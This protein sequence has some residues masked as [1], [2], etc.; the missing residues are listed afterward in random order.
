MSTHH[1]LPEQEA[2]GCAGPNLKFDGL[3]YF[4]QAGKR[5]QEAVGGRSLCL[6]LLLTMLRPRESTNT[7]LTS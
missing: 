7:H 6:R 3:G 1:T 2:I 4:R 5:E